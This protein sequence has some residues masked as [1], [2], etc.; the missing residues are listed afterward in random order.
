MVCI[1]DTILPQEL[2]FAM[3]YLLLGLLASLR[4]W[5]TLDRDFFFSS[6]FHLQM[7]HG[8]PEMVSTKYW[9]LQFSHRTMGIF[10][11]L[12]I[13]QP[14]RGGDVFRTTV[15]QT[16]WDELLALWSELTLLTNSE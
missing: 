9:F 11:L 4:S 14:M 2:I 10:T 15:A 12:S 8:S 16:C 5:A 7:K 6:F 13:L 3:A 1:A